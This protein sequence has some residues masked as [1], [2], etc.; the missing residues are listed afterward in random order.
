MK[1]KGTIGSLEVSILIDLGATN[2]F[3]SFF[4]VGRL[5]LLITERGKFEVTLGNGGKFWGK[6]ECKELLLTL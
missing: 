5:K 2:N 4:T 3:I 6:G 1:R